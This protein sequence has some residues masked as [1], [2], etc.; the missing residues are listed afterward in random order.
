MYRNPTRGY[1]VESGSSLPHGISERDMLIE[2]MSRFPGSGYNNPNFEAE[3]LTR[4]SKYII[5][6]S[7]EDVCIPGERP[8]YKLRFTFTEVKQNIFERLLNVFQKYNKIIIK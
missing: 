8:E 5:T 7:R 2:I 3:Y 1:E 4:Y 6:A